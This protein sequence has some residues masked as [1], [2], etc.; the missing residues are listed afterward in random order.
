MLDLL[1]NCRRLGILV[2]VIRAVIDLSYYRIIRVI[3]VFGAIRALP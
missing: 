1:K 2:E 3:R